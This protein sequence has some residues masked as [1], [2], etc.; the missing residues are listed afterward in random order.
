MIIN[1]GTNSDEI[2]RRRH[3]TRYISLHEEFCY[4]DR[5][6]HPEL[7]LYSLQLVTGATS[8]IERGNT[9]RNVLS[10]DISR[11]KSQATYFIRCGK[12]S[13]AAISTTYRNILDERLE[14]EIGNVVA[15]E[16]I[17]QRANIWEPTS[18]KLRRDPRTASGKA[19]VA[20]GVATRI[21]NNRIYSEPV[22][23]GALH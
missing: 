20:Q 9:Q 23:V 13:T 19:L 4:P 14:L 12:R 15:E 3:Q 1:L 16:L 17:I 10:P 8:C 22:A 21:Q 6:Q 5:F 2:P 18:V 11:R 7:K